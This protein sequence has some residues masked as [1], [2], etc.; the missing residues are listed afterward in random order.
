MACLRNWASHFCLPPP[1]NKSAIFTA[2][3]DI[4][5]NPDFTAQISYLSTEE[6]G[7]KTPVSSGFR[8]KIKFEYIAREI[9]GEQLFADDELVY[10]GDTVTAQIGLLSPELFT[11][12]LTVGTTFDLIINE[13]TIATGVIKEIVNKELEN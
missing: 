11:N 4:E 3:M 13:K 5:E 2:E 6:G 8:T 9:L 10:A 12:S 7:L 1:L